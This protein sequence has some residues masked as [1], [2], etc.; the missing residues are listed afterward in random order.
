M[1]VTHSNYPRLIES[2]SKCLNSLSCPSVSTDHVSQSGHS[3][4]ASINSTNS[5]EDT[6]VVTGE[7][8][9]WTTWGQVIDQWDYM[10]NKK[11]YRVKVT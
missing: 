3:R 5:V 4:Q 8:D 6:T 10:G 1:F 9:L 7:E 11:L 2:D